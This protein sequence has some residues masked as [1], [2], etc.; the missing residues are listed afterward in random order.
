MSARHPKNI[1]KY[2]TLEEQDPSEV[3]VTN[4]SQLHELNLQQETTQQQK[5]AEKISLNFND[6]QV[7]I[8]H[9]LD[10]ED[11]ISDL[12]SPPQRVTFQ[13]ANSYSLSPENTLRVPN[14]KKKKRKSSLKQNKSGKTTQAHSTQSN[15]HSL[16]KNS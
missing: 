11:T 1:K 3:K 16:Q 14:K 9:C 6:P 13:L 2:S 5:T 12:E 15:K 8:K 7:Y 4:L 10:R